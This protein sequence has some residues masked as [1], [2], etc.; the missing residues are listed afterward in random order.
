MIPLAGAALAVNLVGSAASFFGKREQARR[1]RD[2]TLEGVRRLDLEN[3]RKL[4]L[5]RATG[6]ASGVETGSASLTTYLDAMATEMRRQ[7]EWA[8]KNGMQSADDLDGAAGFGLASDIGSSMFSFG[9]ANNWW[10]KPA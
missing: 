3:A 1:M 6:A 2:E 10:K 5:A 9:A 4:G 7:S 8:R